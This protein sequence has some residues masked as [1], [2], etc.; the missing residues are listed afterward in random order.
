MRLFVERAEAVQV[1]FRL[2]AGNVRPVVSICRRLDGLPLAIELAAAR[3]R[4]LSAA[5]VAARLDD[6][7][8]LLTTGSRVA[9]RRQ[10]TLRATLEWS[11]DLLTPPEQTL[12][13]RLS[14]FSGGWTLD[15]A[16]AVCGF[17]AIRNEQVLDLLGQLVDRSLVL[18]LPAP[19][20]GQRY[21]LQ[22]SVRLFAAEQLSD[23][24]ALRQRHACF[25]L[26]VAGQAARELVGP[27]EPEVLP[28]IDAE[29]DNLR[30]ALRHFLTTGHHHEAQGLAGSLGLYW[31]FRS[32]LAEGRGWLDEVLAAP[33][34][35]GSAAARAHCLLAASNVALAQ[36][37]YPNAL[38]YGTES[39][40]TWRALADTR[41]EAAALSLVG[42]LTR[43]AGD[44]ARAEAMLRDAVRKAHATDNVSYEVLALVALAD[45][46]TLQERPGTAEQLTREGLNR[47]H[48]SGRARLI[49]HA[50]RALADAAFER[51][52][53]DTA[54]GF[55][56]RA[57][58]LARERVPSAWWVLQLLLS[59]AKAAVGQHD[60]GSATSAV[61]EALT[62]SRRV[63]DQAGVAAALETCAYLASA[64][65][66]PRRALRLQVAAERL[67]AAIG[68]Q[69]LTPVGG[70]VRRQLELQLAASLGAEARRSIGEAAATEPLEQSIARALAFPGGEPEPG[71][72][73]PVPA[74]VLTPRERE[75]ARLVAQGLSNRQVAEQLVLTEKT[76]ANHVGR[77]FEK[78]GVHSRGQ[79]AA[80]A[81]ELGLHVG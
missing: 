42:Q 24:D 68:P 78:L 17:D 40:Q 1:E 65:R 30:A 9:P 22:E 53:P 81:T 61:G 74:D 3:M 54:R 12:L 23:A 25:Y 34:S 80:R 49:V 16:E 10:Q 44:D 5:D 69:L 66:Q 35:P 50:L 33:Q 13:Q 2:D 77:V 38:R 45:L 56:D 15:A 7:F 32:M 62:L 70:R 73:A 4:M 47:A 71:D 67:R 20:G 21:R 51:G 48:A 14:V 72:A 58:A 59:Q 11:Y 36:G 29:H 46:A 76:A 64:Q 52:D 79:L 28:R 63:N 39:L 60:F 19:S 43:L 75:V 27:A 31:F 41:Q 57:V 6:R 8:R 37:D 55:A 26:D 18:A